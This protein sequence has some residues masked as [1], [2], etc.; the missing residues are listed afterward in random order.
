M[1]VQKQTLST[2]KKGSVGERVISP[3][4]L[5]RSGSGCWRSERSC[6]WNP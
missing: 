3:S 6:S 4:S 2:V 1:A 5:Y